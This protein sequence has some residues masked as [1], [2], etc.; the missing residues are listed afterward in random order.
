MKII[1]DEK[2]MLNKSLSEGYIDKKPTNTIKVLAKHFLNI[3]Q[4]K[5]QTLNSIDNFMTKNH[6]S[7]NFI[8]WQSIIKGI[9]NKISKQDTIKYNEIKKI[10][11]YIEELEVIKNINNLRLEK[12]AFSL[13]VYSKIY[14][15]MNNNETNWVNSPLKDVV[16]DT[17]MAIS[18]KDQRLMVNKLSSLG[19][20]EVSKMVD[21]TNIKVLF[22]KLEGQIAFE[23]TDFRD[24]IY[25]Y[26]RWNGEKIGICEGK[27]CGRL[28][29]ISN[30]RQKYCSTCWKEKEHEDNK[31]Y[32]R[33]GMRKLRQKQNVK[34]LETPSQPL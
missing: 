5:E 30:N 15:Q 28:I 11:I 3:G 29:K 17:K 23:I 8:S 6:K 9:I 24:F 34:G 12:L 13:L 32:A 22:A 14:N 16:S 33:E 4:D 10:T 7:Y 21:C 27:D 20:V 26:L 2:E 19:L 1:L 31:R 18:K 25:E